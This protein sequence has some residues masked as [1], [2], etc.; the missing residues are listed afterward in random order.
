[1]YLSQLIIFLSNNSV[2][3]SK[4]ERDRETERERERETQRERERESIHLSGQSLCM[5]LNSSYFLVMKASDL[6][7]PS[8][9]VSFSNGSHT[10]L[11]TPYDYS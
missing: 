6:G 7:Q 8:P 11:E 1:V 5:S 2:R 4:R 9:L 3:E 10:L